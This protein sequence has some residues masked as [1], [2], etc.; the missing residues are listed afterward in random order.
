MNKTNAA[1]ILDRLGVNYEL[2][3]YEVDESDLSA[4]SVANKLDQNVDQVFKTLVLKGDKS[5]VFVCIIPGASELNLKKAAGLSGNKNVAMVAVKEI[6]E[7]TGYI[8]GGCSPLGMKKTYPT[9]IDETITLFD[10]VFVSA[11]V[12][13]MQI[14]L[15]PDDLIKA[16]GGMT[17]DLI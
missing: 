8:R 3:E 14:R 17:G 12:R 9:Y 10:F 7:L 13:G 11:G 15:G 4:V 6:L 2:H 5:G 16:T 1:R